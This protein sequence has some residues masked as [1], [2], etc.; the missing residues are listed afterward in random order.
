M[1]YRKAPNILIA[2]L[3]VLGV[4]TN[5]ALSE[6]C[7]CGEACLHC[8]QLDS[9]A[10]YPFHMRCSDIPCKSCELERGQTLKTVNS[11]NQTYSAKLLDNA[12]FLFTILDSH[13]TSH[14]LVNVESSYSLR[15]IPSS[16]IYLQNRSILC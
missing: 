3:L 15:A 2:L 8:L 9:K 10:N 12:L 1:R 11:A 6:V 4:S 16:P 7:F 14:A 5:S 13:S